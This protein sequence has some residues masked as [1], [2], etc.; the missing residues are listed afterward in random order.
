[1]KRLTLESLETR[2]VLATLIGGQVVDDLNAN[3]QIDPDEPGIGGVTTY[4]DL[5]ENGELEP[6]QARYVIFQ[7]DAS[8]G[9]DPHAAGVKVASVET[10]QVEPRYKYE[11]TSPLAIKTGRMEGYVAYPNINMTEQMVDAMEATRAYE[12]NVGVIEITKSMAGQTL[13]ILG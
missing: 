8:L 3:G 1:M 10:E 4:L 6:Y 2:R 13:R 12:A 9:S 7:A 5:N 11:P